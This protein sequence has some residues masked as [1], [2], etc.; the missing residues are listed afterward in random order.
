MKSVREVNKRTSALHGT[1]SSYISDKQ[2]VRK[3]RCSTCGLVT[4]SDEN[5][6]FFRA[7]K[8]ATFDSYY[9]GCSG[10]S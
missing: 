6:P 7:Q 3:A 9:C 2:S 10:W 4:N 8:E 1:V 5:L